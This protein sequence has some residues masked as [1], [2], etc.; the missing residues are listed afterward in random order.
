MTVTIEKAQDADSAVC[1]D[2]IS[3]WIDE[4]DWMPRIHTHDE[5]KRFV[6]GLIGAGRVWIARQGV[7]IKG[8]I[9]TN[10]G[11]IGCLYL[12]QTARGNGFGKHLLDYAKASNPDGLNLWTFATNTGAIRFY[13]REG[14]HEVARTDG[15]NDEGLPDIQMYWPGRTNT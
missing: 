3:G 9:E 4:T 2:I 5:D 14:L 10:D 8:L 13:E 15:E 11:W 12:A 6:A 1:A 7:D